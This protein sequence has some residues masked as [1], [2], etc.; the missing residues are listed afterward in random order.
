MSMSPCTKPLNPSNMEVYL[1]S[2][3]MGETEYLVFKKNLSDNT[4]S[5]IG[6][7]YPAEMSYCGIKDIAAL[8][9]KV[10]EGK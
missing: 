1:D 4:C 7:D 2:M 6:C 9:H 10:M 3:P 5:L 8:F